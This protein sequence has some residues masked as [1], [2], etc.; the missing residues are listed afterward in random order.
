MAITEREIAEIAGVSRGTV[1]RVIHNR[2]R[3]DPEVHR[4]VS[5]VAEEHGFTPSHM[6]RALALA[7]NPV[8]IGVIVHLTKISFFQVV[9]Q[10]LKEARQ[11]IARL[12]GELI[13]KEQRDIDADEQMKLL[14]E[15][16]ADNV[17]GVVISPA[18]DARVR[19]YLNDLHQ[20]IGIP[21][22]TFNT[23]LEG[24]ER[25]CYVGVDYVKEGRTCAY[26]MDLLLRGKGGKILII[27]GHLTQPS[28]HLRVEGFAS[29]CGT[30]YPNLEIVAMQF[31]NDEQEKSYEITKTMLRDIDDLDAIILV[32]AGHTGVCKALEELGM[33]EK[34][35]L[36]MFDSLP[37][38][39][40]YLE[41]GVIDFVIDQDANRQGSLPPK[42]LFDYIFNN[43]K[44][45]Q[46]R[47]VGQI[48]VKTKYI[49]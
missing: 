8:K 48:T 36:I 35:K 19:N 41:K 26:L 7:K 10:S 16:V 45:E 9:L 33:S 1:D 34:I 44:P 25:L 46:E 21:I 30:H 15:L 2:G 3:V 13:I 28:N 12:G 24:L 39:D 27:S 4:R 17:Q 5:Q 43:K 37:E 14:D 31:N 40:M 11:E 6:G 29:E 42:I 38:T 22:V 32:S 47:V 20:N 18:Q 49:S 23:D